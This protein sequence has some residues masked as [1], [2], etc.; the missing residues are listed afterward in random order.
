MNAPVMTSPYA[1]ARWWITRHAV[2]QWAGRFDRTATD[3]DAVCT[4]AEVSRGA[5]EPGTAPPG[6]RAA[7]AYGDP[8]AVGW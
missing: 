2:A 3:D 6:G 4:R 1:G 8:P 7:A 5:W